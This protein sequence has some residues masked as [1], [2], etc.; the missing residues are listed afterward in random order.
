MYNICCI[1]F[2]IYGYRSFITILWMSSF[3]YLLNGSKS[4]LLSNI[5]VVY[6]CYNILFWLKMYCKQNFKWPFMQIGQC[7]IHNGILETFMINNLD[8]KVFNCYI[9]LCL[10]CSKNA[11][12]TFKEKSQWKII[13]FL[14]W[15]H[16]YKIHGR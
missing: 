2:F 11:Q 1:D 3:P 5:C 16:W 13:S 4:I 9:F 10:C 15:K 8:L 6:C 14:N 7:L 12:F